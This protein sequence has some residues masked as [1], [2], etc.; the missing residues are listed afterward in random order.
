[1]TD[2]EAHRRLA[3]LFSPGVPLLAAGVLLHA[4]G[5]R[6]AAWPCLVVGTVATALFLGNLGEFLA[7]WRWRRRRCPACGSP[8]RVNSVTDLGM[9]GQYRQDT[10]RVC[11]HTLSYDLTCAACGRRFCFDSGGTCL[12]PADPPAGPLSPVLRGEG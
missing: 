10:D 8:F 7:L 5:W 1:M 11:R 6:V 12:G 3:L 2:Y 9:T 4:E